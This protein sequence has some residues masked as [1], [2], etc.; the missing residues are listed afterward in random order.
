MSIE[1]AICTAR[2]KAMGG[3]V[4]NQMLGQG[5]MESIL[6][7][8]DAGILQI[9]LNRPQSVLMKICMALSRCESYGGRHARNSF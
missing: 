1:K 2:A 9:E 8:L 4:G 3:R 5:C 6:K 7:G